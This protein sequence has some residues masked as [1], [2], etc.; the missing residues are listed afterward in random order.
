MIESI[1]VQTIGL[2]GD[3]E[4]KIDEKDEKFKISLGP[5]RVIPLSILADL[6]PQIIKILNEQ[7]NFPIVSI[8]D[9][10]FAWLKNSISPPTS[11]SLMAP[12]DEGGW[13]PLR[14]AKISL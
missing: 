3:S 1:D 4:V 5:K 6:N 9:G 7:N 8:S 12:K 14:L 2:G 10:K 11:R 13:P